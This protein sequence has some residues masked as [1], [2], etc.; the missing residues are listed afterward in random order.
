MATSPRLLLGPLL[1][2]ERD[3]YYTVCVLIDVGLPAPVLTLSTGATAAFVLAAETPSGRFWRAEIQL[4]PSAAS[5]T[6]GY[7]ITVGGEAAEARTGDHSWAFVI[8]GR[9]ENARLAYAA[10]NGFSSADLAANTAE[11][12]ALWERMERE[13]KKAPFSLLLM[14][15]DQLY[16]DSVLGLEGIKQWTE[17]THDEMDRYQ[18]SN[19]LL[20][21]LD[22]FYD[23]LYLERWSQKTM[24][25]MLASIPSVM[26]WDDHDI[27]DGW[28]SHDEVPQKT[29]MY[30][31]IFRAAKKYFEIYQ[32]RT[33]A[34][35]SLLDPASLT[36][37]DSHY[38]LAFEFADFRVLVM[39]H[40]SQR[41]LD[42][43]MADN[44]HRTVQAWIAAIPPEEPAVGARPVLA[45][46][47]IPIVYR[48]FAALES[49][50]EFT[51][52]TEEAT[53]DVRDH[54]M[55]AHHRGERIR[56]VK[57]LFACPVPL[58]LLSGD[59]HV[60]ALGA[61]HDE[62]TNRSIYQVIS[63]GIVHPPPSAI[64]WAGL[65]FLTNDAPETIPGTKISTE[66]LTPNNGPRYIRDR[67]FATLQRD[68]KGKVWVHWICES[69]VRSS[70]QFVA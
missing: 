58:W 3:S 26:M 34:N 44:Q 41:T 12:Y 29:E 7:G 68:S 4:A 16:A 24:A 67:N 30:K 17:K 25:R 63:T 32:I 49:T 59:V 33:T 43:V 45:L 57:N 27:I 15:G 66:M 22:H 47:G 46:S 35:R 56:L 36:A 50:M 48:S 64:E 13:H 65:R 2:Y 53:D 9:R 52:W 6:V 28:G 55:A 1:G 8:P 38:G 54:W 19:Q 20:T 39:D 11:P 10:C 51:P 70:P 61:L 31:A 37:G 18:P 14:G 42:Q 60:G 69:Q 23:E 21:R 62:E 5:Q 40:R